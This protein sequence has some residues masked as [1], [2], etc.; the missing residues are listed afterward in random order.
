MSLRCVPSPPDPPRL[1]ASLSHLHAP[2]KSSFVLGRYGYQSPY[3]MQPR[4]QGRINSRQCW[5]ASNGGNNDS[6]DRSKQQ[7]GVMDGNSS[8]SAGQACATKRCTKCGEAKALGEFHR[9]AA[10]KDGRCPWCRSCWSAYSRNRWLDAEF[11]AANRRRVQ[12]RREK[13]RAST[14]SITSPSA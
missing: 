7:G 5:E 9:Q 13:L 8:E 1:L 6:L 14:A 2:V 11:R 3:R 4:R 10:N 12:A